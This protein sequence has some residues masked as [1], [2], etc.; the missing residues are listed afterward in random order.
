MTPAL[1]SVLLV[2]GSSVPYLPSGGTKPRA[3]TQGGSV[4]AALHEKIN[5]GL[6]ATEERDAGRKDGEE[7]KK[8]KFLFLAA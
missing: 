5:Q 8:W 1:F 6:N 7:R 3:G 2:V 4:G